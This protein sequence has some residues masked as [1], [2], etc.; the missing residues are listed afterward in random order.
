MT[1]AYGLR[2]L[3][4]TSTGHTGLHE[5]YVEMPALNEPKP[6]TTPTARFWRAP[7][8][9]KPEL[10]EISNGKSEWIPVSVSELGNRRHVRRH[11][12]KK[13]E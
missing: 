8:R 6:P 2:H 3:A 4:A 5:R 12:A 13:L 10:G 1:L 11:G 7:A 9:M